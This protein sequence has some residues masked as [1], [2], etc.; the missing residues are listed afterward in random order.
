MRHHCNFRQAGR[1]TIAKTVV[2]AF[3]G[4]LIYVGFLTGRFYYDF[5]NIES[6]AVE[7]LRLDRKHGID[8][9]RNRYLKFINESTVPLYGED[10]EFYEEDG[11]Y[12]VRGQYQESLNLFGFHIHTFVF[13]LHK[14]VNKDRI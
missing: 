5:A 9:I 2:L 11:K 12:H 14:S 8:R 13:K 6:R 1:I 10:L 4:L 3:I 7:I